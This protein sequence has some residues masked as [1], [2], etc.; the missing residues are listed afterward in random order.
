MAVRRARAVRARRWSRLNANA[1]AGTATGAADWR[2][3]WRDLLSTACAVAYAT[4]GAR[5]FSRAATRAVS[6][7]GCAQGGHTARRRRL[8]E[9]LVRAEEAPEVLQ[10][11]QGIGRLPEVRGTVAR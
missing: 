6:T 9:G 5:D 3:S 1:S 8:S 4:E 10:E 11:P 2:T 7:G